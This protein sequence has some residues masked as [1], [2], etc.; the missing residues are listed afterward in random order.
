MSKWWQTTTMYQIYPRSYMDSNG[1]GIGDL[2]GIIS[3]LD[4]IKEMGFETIWISP[5][6]NSPQQDFGYDVTDYF[7]IA[8]EYG[9]M[10]DAEKLIAEVH[11]RGMRLVFDMIFGHTSTQHPWFEE[12]RSSRNNPKSDW[13][14]WRDGKGKKPPTNW[15]S[16][17]GVNGWQYEPRRD[18]WFY[19][20]FLY[21]QPDL[22]FRNP[23]VK[24]AMFDTVR[25]WLKKG[26]DGFRLDLFHA[27]YKDDQCRDNP[28]SFK[29][30][31]SVDS[32]DGANQVK[33]YTMN[34]PENFVLAKELRQVS[35]KFKPERVLLGEVFG[36][37][38]IIKGYLGNKADGLHWIF[39][40][41]MLG[42]KY[43]GSF[44]KSILK[45][46]E[47]FYPSPLVPIYVFG[48][49]DQKRAISKI[50]NDRAKA[51]LIALLQLTPRGIPVV[52]YGEEIGIKDGDFPIKGGKD[53]IA[54]QFSWIPKKV[55]EALG[56]YLNRDSCR[57]PMQWDG[58]DNAGFNKNGDKPWLPVNDDYRTNNVAA[59]KSDPWSLLNLYK[60]VLN[61]RKSS[62]ALQDG[63]MELIE[64]KGIGKDLVVYHR[65]QGKDEILV[66][67]NF[68]K[69]PAV[70]TN[71]TRCGSVVTATSPDVR[72]DGS[73]V[74]LPPFSG[75]LLEKK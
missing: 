3:K 45:K 46:F 29:A 70:F 10:K 25:F 37:Q 30:G 33:K 62:K 35:D 24:E 55:A 27:V 43:N 48:N 4:Y 16:I 7:S 32:H 69:T 8:P 58:T 52:Y 26:V 13:Y 59:Q 34:L 22:N 64:G 5:F 75:A 65:V 50:G 54:I 47:T 9:T 12:S 57:T 40:F 2:K 31:Q 17:T 18:Q 56:L 42:F 11:K 61:Y 71:S 36:K 74:S 73:S 14:I 72:V 19:T 67:L 23:E 53:P 51:K 20:N 63:S 6:Y 15:K 28:F 41:E 44:F 49:H 1:D 68:G 38:E 60:K 21:F 66:V 39:L